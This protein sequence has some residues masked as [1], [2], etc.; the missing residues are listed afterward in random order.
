MKQ[1]GALDQ[2]SETAATRGLTCRVTRGSFS[3]RDWPAV[4]MSL[5]DLRK[6]WEQAFGSGS[7]LLDDEAPEREADLELL[8][9]SA[10][11]LPRIHALVEEGKIGNV[12]PPEQGFALDILTT[13]EK[14]TAVLRAGDRLGLQYAVYG[15]AEHFLGMRFVHPLTDLQPEKP[16]MPGELHLVESPSVTLRVLYENAHVRSGLRGTTGKSAHFSDVGAWRW[17]DWAGK[18]ERMRHWVAWGVKNRVNVIFFDDTMYDDLKYTKP[19]A[20]SDALWRYIDSRGLKTLSF[21][22]PGE[23][24]SP[25]GAYSKDDLCNPD[26]S[27]VP[28]WD[29]HLCIGKPRFWKD[30]DE[31]LDLLAPHAHRL[32]GIFT[33]WLES[34]CGEGV[35]EGS[36]DGMIHK[37]Y[38]YEMNMSSAR[39]HKPVL[40]KGG[41]CTGC[42]HMYNV[43]KWVKHLEY[44]N[45]RTAAHGLPPAG[46]G[47]AFWGVAEP[48]DG[49]VAERVVP[50]L[51]PGSLS[52]VACLP[53]CHRAERVE[54]WP[55]IM[56]EVNRTD[57]GNRR[58]MLLRELLYGCGSDMP[59]VPFTNLDRVDDDWRVFGKYKSTATTFGIVYVYHSMGW[60][61][62][63]YSMRKQWQTDQDWKAWFRRYFAVLLSDEFI[64]A[65]LDIATTIQD[66]QLL[67]GLEPGEEPGSYYSRWGLDINKLAPETL[68]E[69]PL[70]VDDQAAGGVLG[71]Q[72]FVRLV[73]AGSADQQGDYTSERC[74][75]A[76]KRLLSLRSKIEH[77]IEKM[78]VLKDNLPTGENSCVWN[79]FVLL[80]LRVTTRFL[81]ARILLAQSYMTYIRMRERVVQ[82]LDT[83]ADAAEGQTLCRQA[84]DA[85]D[86]Y[87]RLR[88]G[89]AGDY[90]KEVN[91]DTLR[92]LICWWQRLSNEP[93]LCRDLD[94]CAFLDRVET[95][96][97]T[98]LRKF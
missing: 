27:R 55:R 12:Q 62:Q 7:F 51:P 38:D 19:F 76:L 72:R 50:H 74:A 78:R 14:R 54:A 6:Y 90:P 9:G 80:P 45:T 24:E 49:M 70:Q 40:S 21:C 97:E 75:P 82:G 98:G 67:E 60:L 42:G 33:N 32:A 68:A 3:E 64:E 30:A 4:K 44:L 10:E 39:F 29:R 89:F 87:I 2:S 17:E 23:A 65:F 86:E 81:Q 83:S 35:T 58:V 11:N 96:T 53:S 56:D 20:V 18:P 47:R 13:G 85:Q 71:G 31:W 22:G 8:I 5:E 43:D 48:D 91:P 73:K 66:V 59:I 69:G 93:Q 26:A 57:N 79:E 92:N 37:S 25:K 41:G 36:E 63:L 1:G 95:E 46:L 15:F 94:I 34:T 77:A 28:P 52:N 16:P 61:L 84:L 88:P